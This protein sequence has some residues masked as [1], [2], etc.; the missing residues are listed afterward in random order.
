MDDSGHGLSKEGEELIYLFGTPPRLP[1][2]FHLQNPRREP[3]SFRHQTPRIRKKYLTN[4]TR[5]ALLLAL[6]ASALIEFWE[7]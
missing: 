2:D 3:S 6:E 1:L 7:C 5:C 4:F